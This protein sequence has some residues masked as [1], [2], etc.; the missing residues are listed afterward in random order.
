MSKATDRQQHPSFGLLSLHRIQGNTRLFGSELVHQHFVS[1]KVCTAE[2]VESYGEE[3]YN[4]T[5]TEIEVFLSWS[6]FVEAIGTMNVCPG[7]PCTLR[8]IKG[9]G[10]IDQPPRP[11]S[12]SA[13]MRAYAD[14]TV[15]E[16]AKLADEI[17][18]EASKTKG[19]SRAKI[20]DM[21]RTL[22]SWASS[23]LSFVLEQ[24]QEQVDKMVS[25]GRVEVVETA[26]GVLTKLGMQALQ[27][28][29]PAFVNEEKPHE[30]EEAPRD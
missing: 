26:R 25:R 10:Y 15:G 7:Q 6:Q 30:L 18:A 14:K 12:I 23:N 17:H 2:V 27:G 3:K 4:P 20:R 8:F 21:S 16:L 19:M 22:A 9:K 28:Q 13:R 5:G 1:L 11:V 24:T 29:L